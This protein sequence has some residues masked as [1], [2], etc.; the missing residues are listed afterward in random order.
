M[1]LFRTLATLVGALAFTATVFAQQRAVM[2]NTRTS[3]D[4]VYVSTPTPRL[5]AGTSFYPYTPDASVKLYVKGK[6]VIESLTVFGVFTS[7]AIDS[8]F[9]DV[10]VATNT[11]AATRLA[12]DIA[13]RVSTAAESSARA[14]ADTVLSNSTVSIRTDLGIET[15]RA[16]AAENVLS[17]ST[18]A[19]ISSKGRANGIASLDGGAKIPIA[20]LPNSV[21]EYQGMWVPGT[22]T[23]TLADG[24]GNNGDVYRASADGSANTGHGSITY[25]IGDFVIYNGA[26]WERSPMADGVSMVNGYTGAVAL[27][28][29]DIPE[30][31]TPT[32][33]WFT[34][35]RAQAAVQPTFNEVAVSTTIETARA[36]AAELANTT[37]INSTGSALTLET[38]RAVA[39]EMVNYSAINSTGSALTVETARATAAELVNYSAINS[40]GSALTIETARAI[41]AELAN[42]T[43]INSTGSAL[44]IET[45][46]A[47]AAEALKAPIDNPSFT[48]NVTATVFLGAL[49]GNAATASALA[50]NPSDCASNQFANTIAANGNL[51]CA[52][53]ADADVPDTITA[54]NYLPL[55]GG[56]MTAGTL[57]ASTMVVTGRLT[58]KDVVESSNAFTGTNIAWSS[59]TIH[60][61]TLTAPVTLTFTGAI[62]QQT[63]TLFL[64][65]DATGSRI[66]TWPTMKWPSATAPT[67]TTTAN[68]VDII[69]IYYDGTDY[70]GFVG[71]QAY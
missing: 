17:A 15:A 52:A 54:S 9:N 44:T 18:A 13:I 25:Y 21:M 10:A 1:K 16:I 19:I 11:E 20:Q 49:T 35:A 41:A 32:N 47:T 28:T 30:P 6:G 39:A 46:R 51:S 57:N 5:L 2:E 55:S 50:S 61:I 69:S 24:T 71:G 31:V 40:T 66:V 33:K 7:T 42:T 23:P 48:G 22:N 64:K 36:I 37:A 12:A 56:T 3:G 62:A 59:G 65:Q 58:I 4:A 45:A 27:K 38:A 8:R 43:A 70:F 60:T 26:I 14:S 34:D 53:I 63:I 29:D 67:L 68:K